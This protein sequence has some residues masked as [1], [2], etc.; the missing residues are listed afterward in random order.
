MR[1]LRERSSQRKIN[2]KDRRQV[3]RGAWEA[4]EIL[5]ELVETGV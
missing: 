2:K 4:A 1:D 5:G 3:E